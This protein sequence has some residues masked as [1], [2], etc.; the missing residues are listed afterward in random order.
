MRTA[1]N[2]DKSIRSVENVLIGRLRHRAYLPV[3]H[4]TL[5]ALF[6]HI[7]SILEGVCLYEHCALLTLLRAI[8]CDRH[9]GYL[10][11]EELLTVNTEKL[12][13]GSSLDGFNG[14]LSTD[15]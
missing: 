9:E 11:V 3:R 14:E 8:L 4:R 12:L 15:H 6:Q 10:A 5:H 2:I 1:L 13:E 7:K